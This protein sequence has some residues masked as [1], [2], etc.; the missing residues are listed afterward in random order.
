LVSGEAFVDE[1]EPLGDCGELVGEA[2][3]VPVIGAMGTMPLVGS[4]L[5]K[6]EMR[7]P[8]EL[9]EDAGIRPLSGF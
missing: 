7:L 1:P 4:T 2:R 6:P 9:G 5:G 3:G 8:V